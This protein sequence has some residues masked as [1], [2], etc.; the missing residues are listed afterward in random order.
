MIDR[1]MRL[2]SKIGA[3]RVHGHGRRWGAH[4]YCR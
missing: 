2:L 3:L 4:L 1:V